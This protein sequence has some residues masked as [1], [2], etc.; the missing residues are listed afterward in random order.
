MST[1]T[2]T[3]RSTHATI[4]ASG[5][6]WHRFGEMSSD[7]M[8]RAVVHVD[9]E[10]VLLGDVVTIRGERSARLLFDCGRARVDGLG[11]GLASGEVIVDGDAGC[12]IGARMTGGSI[13]VRGNVGH[14]AGVSMRGGELRV[15]GNAGD[16]LGANASGTRQGMTGGEIVVRGDAGCNVAARARRGLV[17]VAGNAGA[18][19]ARDMIAGTVVVFGRIDGRPG[20]GNKRGT[21]VA[22]GSV[23]VPWTYRLACT[24]EPPFIRLLA[25]YLTRRFGLDVDPRIASGPF[26][27]YCGDAGTPGRGEILEW[28]RP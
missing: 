17:V 4:D 6:P 8:A 13:H 14:D 5:L 10:R 24:F 2:L 9:H 15:D 19:L 26:R 22:T 18:D 25:T 3:V 20:T 11:V 27:R 1:V 21:I 28:V 16:R 12:R 7:E 23:D